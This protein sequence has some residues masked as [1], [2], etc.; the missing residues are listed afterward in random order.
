M[1]FLAASIVLALAGSETTSDFD[2]GEEEFSVEGDKDDVGMVDYAAEAKKRPADPTY[3][4]LEPEGKEA[5]KNDYPMHVV[6]IGPSWVKVEL[7]VL[8]A[9]DRATFVRDYPHGIRVVTEWDIGS[10]LTTREQ[11][12]TSDQVFESDPTLAFFD[13]AIR[14]ARRSAPVRVKVMVAPLPAP[15]PADDPDAKVA[16]APLKQAYGVTSVFFRPKE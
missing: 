10:N 1:F 13:V 3:F 16:E 5:L 9:S 7:P 12:F 11:R 14:D 15:P 8:V 6:S 4:H 2:L